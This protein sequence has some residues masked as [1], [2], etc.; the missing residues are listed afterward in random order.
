MLL[1]DMASSRPNKT[2]GGY[3]LL[4][5]IGQGAYGKVY[6]AEKE[7][8]KFA[9][10][11]VTMIANDPDKIMSEIKTLAK[12]DRSDAAQPSEHHQLRR[13]VQERP[14]SVHSD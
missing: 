4:E 3:T 10:K 7:G 12:V 9:V 11:E 5:I 6:A 14:G 2:V 1:E 13:V 8:Q